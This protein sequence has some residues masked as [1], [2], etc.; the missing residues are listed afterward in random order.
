MLTIAMRM[1]VAIH[2]SEATVTTSTAAAAAAVADAASAI[3]FG[4]A[5]DDGAGEGGSWS[6]PP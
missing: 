2:N 6:Q 5:L 3:A 1:H 4:A